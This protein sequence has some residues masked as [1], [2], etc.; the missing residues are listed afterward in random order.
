[1]GSW[2]KCDCGNA[3]NRNLFSG[4]NLSLLVHENVL[5]KESIKEQDINVIIMESDKLVKCEVCG[6]IVIMSKDSDDAHFYKKI[7]NKNI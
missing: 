4:N 3:L 1:M 6:C 2:I 5:D 7:M